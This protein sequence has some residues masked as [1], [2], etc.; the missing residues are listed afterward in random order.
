VSDVAGGAPEAGEGEARAIEAT[1]SAGVAPAASEMA[2]LQIRGL[3]KWYG[4]TRAL[5]GLDLDARRGEILGIA[6]PN[7]AGKS[8][9]IKI[10]A[11]ETYADDGDIQLDGQPWDGGTEADRVAVVHQEPQLFPNLTVAENLMVGREGTRAL[12]R[13]LRASE[14]QLMTDLAILDVADVP[15]R[16]VTLAT[17]QRVEIARALARDARIFLFDE[18]NSAL[19]QEESS[20]LFGRMHLLARGGKVVLL[21]SHRIA[22]LSRHADRVALII[23]GVCT[24]VLEG[25]ALTQEGIADGL[26]TGEAHREPDERVAAHVAADAPTTLRLQA[27]THGGGE[28]SDIELQVPAGEIV[29]FVGVEG[30]GA[31]ELVRSIAGFERAAGSIEIA[32]REGPAQAR[33]GTSLVSADRA[34]SLFGNLSVGDNLVSRLGREITTVG[35]ALR[36]RR[37]HG[38]A[39]E[40][41]DRFQVKASSI[42]L[43]VRSLSGGNQQKVAIAAA[44]VKGPKVLVLEEPTRGVD[45]GSKREIYHHMRQYA[46]GGRAVIIYC[47]EVPEVFEAADRAFVVS[48]G[49][50]SAPLD[51]ASFVDVETLARAITRLERHGSVAPPA[52]AAASGTMA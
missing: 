29:A 21:V 19:T 35:G 45:V 47:T 32:G 40:L 48:D 11:G 20:D 42:D 33:A 4:D 10:L 52:T 43:P 1:G 9:L 27:W 25:D 34:T 41:R 18:P 28:F 46:N 17:Q 26:V 7:G 22:E 15:L 31:R 50:L 3:R 12:V 14:R 38:I 23:D 8:T 13:D 5:D 44:I 39:A 6:G 2:G 37:M 49:R 36:R 16:K 51:V 24:D 30:S